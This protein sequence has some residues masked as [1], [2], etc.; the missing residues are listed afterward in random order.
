[1]RILF[2]G[3]GDIAIPSFEALLGE[4]LIGLVT[5]PDKP[6]G[7]KQILTPPRIKEIAIE[8]GVEVLQPEKASESTFLDRL[9]F[10]APDIIVVMAYG[11]ILT[12]RFLD[13]ANVACINLHAS[14]LPRHRGAACIQAAIDA[15]DAETGITVMHVVKKL[16]AG[17]IILQR[18]I[19]IHEDETSG[20]LHDR[21]AELAPFALLEA[22]QKLTDGTATRTP[23]QEEEASYISKLMRDDGEIDWTMTAEEIE[24]RIRAY[25]PWPG[26]STI[27]TET[28][29]RHKGRTKRLKIFPP[30]Q[31]SAMSGNTGEVLSVDGALVIGCAGAALQVTEVQPDGSR[32]MKTDDFLRGQPLQVGD[33]LGS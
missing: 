11:Q 5:Q 2:M 33:R 12:Q 29:G 9:E 31:V 26:T 4:Q 10:M 8:H 30:A 14:L 15:G 7:R 21:L 16:D 20:E 25:H 24:R 32:R 13:I 27:Y 6:V 18:A 22:L 23:Q 19:P 3:T 28:T 17:D 1:M